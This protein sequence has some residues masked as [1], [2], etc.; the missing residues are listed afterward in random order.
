MSR[1]YITKLELDDSDEYFCYTAEKILM[2]A[3]VLRVIENDRTKEV[4]ANLEMFFRFA[5]FTF[6]FILI[7][8]QVM[9]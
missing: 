8:G 3:H 7:V 1:L 5:A 6:I 2:G 4:V 9:K